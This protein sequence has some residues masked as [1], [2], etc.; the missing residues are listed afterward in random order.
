MEGR[1]KRD[2]IENK[3]ANQELIISDLNPY[4]INE[5]S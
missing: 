3:K 4:D 5:R 2:V 1:E